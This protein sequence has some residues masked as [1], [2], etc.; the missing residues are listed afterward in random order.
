MLPK[1]SLMTLLNTC[2]IWSPVLKS[3][4][5]SHFISK[6]NTEF[7]GNSSTGIKRKVW[8][9]I[10]G[11]PNNHNTVS[12]SKCTWRR[13]RRRPSGAGW[14]RWYQIWYS[15]VDEVSARVECS[16]RNRSHRLL[17]LP[18]SAQQFLWSSLR[19]GLSEGSPLTKETENP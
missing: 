7:L 17:Q 16:F 8:F 9:L 5:I 19:I 15:L 6:L 13:R 10:V 18:D 14:R 2:V 1:A 3:N 4:S 11:S 12:N